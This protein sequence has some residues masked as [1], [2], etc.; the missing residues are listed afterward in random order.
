MFVNAIYGQ[1]VQRKF[2]TKLYIFSLFRIACLALSMVSGD[3]LVLAP[4]SFLRS[5]RRIKYFKQHPLLILQQVSF[6]Y[7]HLH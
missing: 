1:H 6:F 7:Y 3:T 2:R 4:T 5:A